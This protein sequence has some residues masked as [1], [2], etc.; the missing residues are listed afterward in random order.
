MRLRPR[1]KHKREPQHCRKSK[2]AK[3]E[4]ATKHSRE[5]FA[6]NMSA[7][8]SP[9]QSALAPAGVTSFILS[10]D[11]FIFIS[12]LVLFFLLHWKSFFTLQSSSNFL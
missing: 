10:L 2:T 9:S 7:R 6:A 5:S 3:P 4:A 8:G 1:K 12:I 11:A